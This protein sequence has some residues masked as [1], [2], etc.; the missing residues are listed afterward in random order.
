MGV[1]KMTKFETA[2]IKRIDIFLKLF[3]NFLVIK[4]IESNT[5]KSLTDKQLET[6]T[7]VATDKLKTINENIKTYS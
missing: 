5:V 6:I 7:P 1:K 3:S 4:T 2:I